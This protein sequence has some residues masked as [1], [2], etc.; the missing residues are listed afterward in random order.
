MTGSLQV[1]KNQFYMVLSFQDETGK[2]KHKWIKT[3]LEVRGNKTRAKEMLRH[4]L[5]EYDKK[6]C[7]QYNFHE[8][9]ALPL[10]GFWL[11]LKLRRLRFSGL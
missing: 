2:W 5:E 4:T 6:K 10:T 11:V 7:H 8:G 1:K 3:G 9:D